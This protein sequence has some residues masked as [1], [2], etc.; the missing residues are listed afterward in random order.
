[1]ETLE[2]DAAGSSWRCATTTGWRASTCAPSAPSSPP[3]TSSSS[4]SSGGA[5]GGAAL[6]RQGERRRVRDEEAAEGGDGGE[7]AGEPRPRRARRDDRGAGRQP[8]GGKPRLAIAR[9]RRR[10]RRVPCRR[11]R[12]PSLLCAQVRLHFSFQDDECLYLVMEYVPGGGTLFP[13]PA[14]SRTAAALLPLLASG[15]HAT[16]AAPAARR[17]HDEPADEARRADRGGDE[18]LRGAGEPRLPAHR[19]A[20]AL[21]PLLASPVLRSPHACLTAP[22]PTVRRVRPS[23][24]SIRST[25]YRTSIATSSRTTCCSIWTVTSN[26]PI[27]GWSRTSRRYS[28]YRTSRPRHCRPHTT[29]AALP[30]ARIS[31]A[32]LPPAPPLARPLSRVPLL[33]SHP[34]IIRCV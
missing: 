18:V 5:F 25:D 34:V 23:R 19:T 14:T 27:S 22:P 11:H 8:V 29:A 13:Q 2:L 12:P 31:A 17:R 28:T 32:A 4:T 10:R 1:M 15:V 26:C 7:G 33:S 3:P 9:R 30:T 20:A 21:L 16:N 6:P 24:P